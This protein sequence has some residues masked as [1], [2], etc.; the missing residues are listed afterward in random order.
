MLLAAAAMI[1]DILTGEPKRLYDKTGHPVSWMSHIL[2]LLEKHLNKTTF[3]TSARKLY[4]SFSILFCVCICGGIAWALE[5]TV[6]LLLSNS[7][8]IQLIVLALIASIF[9]AARSLYEHIH[10]VKSALETEG[11]Q[12]A[13]EA[14]ALVVGRNTE[15]LDETGI[16]RAATE[17][18]AENFSDGVVSPIFWLVI[19]GLPGLVVFKMV[20]TADSM[21]GHK[22]ERYSD[23]GWASAKLDD[24]LNYIPARL[25]AILFILGSIATNDQH[26]REA[27]MVAVRDS[28]KHVSPNAGWPEAAMAGALHVR[29]G[30]PR[31]Y[32]DTAQKEY[33]W[34][35]EEF[36]TDKKPDL[37]QALKLA[38]LA[39][40]FMV[41]GLTLGGIA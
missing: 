23:F 28:K 14:V 12:A 5:E 15:N 31:Q 26:S 33:A 9:I 41:T 37:G 6:Q 11:L 4:G 36:L 1:W 30:G 8:T 32:S 35:G 22:T 17:S 3:G 34:L 16:A 10:A 18:L 39:W 40:F 27:F 29:L 2:M 38:T 25:T 19:G 13:R 20:N 21:I 7:P 24:A